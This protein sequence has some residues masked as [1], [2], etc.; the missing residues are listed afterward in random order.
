MKKIILILSIFICV[1]SYASTD[2]S[3]I[4]NHIKNNQISEVYQDF[5]DVKNLENFDVTYKIIILDFLSSNKDFN[6]L[7]S[8][9][10]KSLKVELLCNNKIQ[11]ANSNII[12]II[13]SIIDVDIL[14]KIQYNIQP[15]KQNE[16]ALQII[17]TRINLLQ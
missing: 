15:L 4:T 2:L 11:L 3:E 5:N 16:K 12:K 17:K 13:N 10:L 8:Q 6:Q 9:E 7:N 14:K 1:F